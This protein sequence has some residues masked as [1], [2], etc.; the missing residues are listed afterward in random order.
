MISLDLGNDYIIGIQTLLAVAVM[1][2]V[3]LD[4]FS[5]VRL[6]QQSS[7]LGQTLRPYD[8]IKSDW[9]HSEHIERGPIVL[10]IY[11]QLATACLY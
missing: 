6:G 2:T 7:K 3:N 8:G 4:I 5:P 10:N 9:P 1:E 11:R